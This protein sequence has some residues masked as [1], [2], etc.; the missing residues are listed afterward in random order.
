MTDKNK[1][2]HLKNTIENDKIDNSIMEGET[3]QINQQNNRNTVVVKSI[4]KS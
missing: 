1:N 4:A 3:S 2:F